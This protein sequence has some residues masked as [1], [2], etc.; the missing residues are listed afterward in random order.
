MAVVGMKQYAIPKL[1]SVVETLLIPH[2][3][4][5]TRGINLVIR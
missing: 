5:A 1:V 2:I 4:S 3:V